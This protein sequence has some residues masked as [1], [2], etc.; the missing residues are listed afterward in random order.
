MWD[1][2][3]E[4]ALA[5]NIYKNQTKSKE[6]VWFSAPFACDKETNEVKLDGYT[7]EIIGMDANSFKLG[8]SNK[9]NKQKKGWFDSFELYSYAKAEPIDFNDGEN[10]AT[11][12]EK[13]ACYYILEKIK[14]HF[15]RYLNRNKYLDGVILD[16]PVLDLDKVKRDIDNYFRNK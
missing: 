11:N 15:G 16:D 7:F 8:W 6:K 3:C 10:T 12:S 4:L 2:L 13:E 14:S 9:V 1:P 5:W